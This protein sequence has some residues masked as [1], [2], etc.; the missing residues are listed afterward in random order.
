MIEDQKKEKIEVE[1]IRWPTDTERIQ[2]KFQDQR[3]WKF[4]EKCLQYL[5]PNFIL[6][7]IVIIVIK[8]F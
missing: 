6:I 5:Y 7:Q 2:K 8:V 4:G 1:Q 3:E